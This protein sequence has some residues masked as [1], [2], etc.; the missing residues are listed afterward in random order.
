MTV[1]QQTRQLVLPLGTAD[2]SDVGKECRK[3]VRFHRGNDGVN[4]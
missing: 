4:A 3:A 2:K 1:K